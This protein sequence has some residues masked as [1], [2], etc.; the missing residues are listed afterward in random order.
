VNVVIADALG[1]SA[2]EAALG[3]SVKVV[4]DQLTAIPKGSIATSGVCSG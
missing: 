3:A 4:I 1:G 2:V